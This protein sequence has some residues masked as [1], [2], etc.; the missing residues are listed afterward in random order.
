MGNRWS[1]PWIGKIEPPHIFKIGLR[2]IA[3]ELADQ[4]GSQIADD[5][6]AKLSAV[7]PLLFLH[8]DTSANL[9]IRVDRFSV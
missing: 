6:Y 2:D 7:S 9:V 4:S 5:L 3:S 8:E 1:S